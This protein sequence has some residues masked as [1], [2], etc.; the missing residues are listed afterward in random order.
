MSPRTSY[1]R[2]LAVVT[3]IIFVLTLLVCALILACALI[4]VFLD[5]GWGYRW[6]HIF[7]VLFT[8]VLAWAIYRWTLR[9]YR[10]SWTEAEA[11]RKVR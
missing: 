2:V 4:D 6:D 11:K 9:I 3:K 8:G 5:L 7:G 1:G 10:L